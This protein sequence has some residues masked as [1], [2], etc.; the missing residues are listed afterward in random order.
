LSNVSR[1]KSNSSAAASAP[2]ETNNKDS[3]KKS[4]KPSK[5][6]GPAKV[7]FQNPEHHPFLV[8]LHT[9]NYELVPLSTGERFGGIPVVDVGVGIRDPFQFDLD[10]V[11][12]WGMWSMVAPAWQQPEL[13]QTSDE[14]TIQQFRVEEAAAFD[15]LPAYDEDVESFRV[16]RDSIVEIF[17]ARHA[18]VAA[19]QHHPNAGRKLSRAFVVRH[20][21]LIPV[22][23]T[24]NDAS[25]GATA[26][27]P[28]SHTQGSSAAPRKRRA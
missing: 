28:T 25:S 22:T 6:R 2:S 9:R 7:L 8:Y 20:I 5:A 12:Y 24:R 27:M 14:G 19:I 16:A 3:Q 18:L 17:D 23:G 15:E 11:A 10:E 13:W 21:R 1:I 4:Q 26:R